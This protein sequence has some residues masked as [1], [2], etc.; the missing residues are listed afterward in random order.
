[1]YPMAICSLLTE[2]ILLLIKPC[3]A[4]EHLRSYMQFCPA[5]K[6]VKRTRSWKQSSAFLLLLGNPM[7]DSCEDNGSF[8][9]LYEAC[10]QAGYLCDCWAGVMINKEL[11]KFGFLLCVKSTLMLCCIINYKWKDSTHHRLSI[12][13]VEI[14]LILIMERRK[15]MLPTWCNR[16]VQSQ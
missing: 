11:L 1:M 16:S 9:R 7:F 13:W 10:V 14:R 5:E 6:N 15:G 12:C 8:A 3:L 2:E 4:H